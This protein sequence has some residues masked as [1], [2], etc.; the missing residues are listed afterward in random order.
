MADKQTNAP[1]ASALPVPSNQCMQHAFR[2]SMSDDKPI[3]T[4]YWQTS[5]NKTSL[6]GVRANGDKMLVKNADEYTS[7]IDKIFK[8]ENEFIISTENSLY[9]VSASISSKRIT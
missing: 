2:L 5:H 7:P 3:M 6:I 8:V 9:I 1:V 4:D